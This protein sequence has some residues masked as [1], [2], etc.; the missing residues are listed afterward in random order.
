MIDAATLML[1]LPAALALNVTPGPDMAFCFAQGLSGGWRAALAADLGVGLGGLIHALA[2]GL[3]LAALIAAWPA[4]FETIR[5][6]GVA[7]L[8]WLAVGLVRA[9][10]AAGPRPATRARRAFRDGLATNLTN[11]KVILFFLAFLPQFVDP[12]RG[13]VLGQF[14]ILGAIIAAGGL[15]VNGAVGLAA[16]RLG[17]MASSSP[18]WGR[19]LRWGSAAIFLG[20]A[21]RLAL[22]RR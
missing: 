15:V 3:G 11:P 21:A 4:A 5:W 8:V 9:G 20:V 19:L 14:L 16:G 7:Y 1:F 10:D 6:V 18:V 12:A 22:D 2:A 13:S 17:G